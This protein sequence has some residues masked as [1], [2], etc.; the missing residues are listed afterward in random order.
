MMYRPLS[1]ALLCMVTCNR[2][3]NP[4]DDLKKIFQDQ[5]LYSYLKALPA[6]DRENLEKIA[7]HFK[8]L[9]LVGA[10]PFSLDE[11][12]FEDIETLR[13]KTAKSRIIGMHPGKTQTEAI[14]QLVFVLEKQKPVQLALWTTGIT[15]SA[16]LG[17]GI[18]DGE[19]LLLPFCSLVAVSG[20]KYG[21]DLYFDHKNNIGATVY[22]TSKQ[23]LQQLSEADKHFMQ[24]KISYTKVLYDQRYFA[25]ASALTALISYM[26]PSERGS[27]N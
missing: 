8:F 2:A 3:S 19:S 15:S 20:I 22:Y 11:Y 4:N 14:E 24:G 12:S 10:T 25:G 27:K 7:P 17:K 16:I 5:G 18:K 13:K 6:Q 21:S 26:L 9:R 1:L 23:N